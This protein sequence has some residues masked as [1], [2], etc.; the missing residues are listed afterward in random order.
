[1]ISTFLSL[2][3]DDVVTDI[4]NDICRYLVSIA[5]IHDTS[6]AF[7]S[8]DVYLPN[9]FTLP[10]R[11]HQ[12]PLTGIAPQSRFI[13]LFYHRHLLRHQRT[14]LAAFTCNTATPACITVTPLI[15]FYCL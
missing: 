6:Y 3:D 2:I 8:G 4:F 9:A 15:R 13:I 7:V 11:H 1:M 5:R 10:P 12:T 14:T